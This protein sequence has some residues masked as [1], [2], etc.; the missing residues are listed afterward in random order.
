MK[1]GLFLVSYIDKVYW[2]VG[3]LTSVI[4]KHLFAE[5]PSDG[6]DTETEFDDVNEIFFPQVMKQWPHMVMIHDIQDEVA[7]LQYIETESETDCDILFRS[8][9][10]TSTK[11]KNF[12]NLGLNN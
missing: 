5:I 1:P 2:K 11:T 10:Y 4:V 12:Q 9:I 3:E 6:L 7:A 8:D